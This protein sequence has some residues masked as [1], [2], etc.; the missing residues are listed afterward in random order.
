[1]IREAVRKEKGLAVITS[2]LR[3]QND[4]V[5]RSTAIC[6]RNLAADLKN[7]ALL[8]T[9]LTVL[10]TGQTLLGTNRIRGKPYYLGTVLTASAAAKIK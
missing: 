4:N 8:G 2:L 3:M 7:K 6:L 9:V 5:V 10:G 1:M